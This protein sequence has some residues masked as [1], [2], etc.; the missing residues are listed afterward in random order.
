MNKKSGRNILPSAIS[1]VLLIVVAIAAE[2]LYGATKYLPL[3]LFALTCLFPAVINLLVML[4]RLRLPEEK[5]EQAENVPVQT[6]SHELIEEQKESAENGEETRKGKKRK[7][8]R[9]NGKGSSKF[10]KAL[11]AVARFYNRNRIWTASIFVLAVT[12]FVQIRFYI[13]QSRLTSL[14]TMNYAVLVGMIFIFTV[15]IALDKWCLHAKTGDLFTDSLLKNLRSILAFLQ[16]ALVLMMIAAALKL[17]GVYDVQTWMRYILIVLFYYMSAF[18]LFSFVVSVI[19][20]SLLDSPVLIVPSPFAI[21]SSKELGLITYF[22]ENTGMTMRSLWS[23]RMIKKLIPYTVVLAALLFWF[24][25]GVVQV[26]ANQTAVV[27]R[28]GQMIDEPL[29][30]GIHLCLPQPFDK[31]EIYNTEDVQRITVGYVSDEDQ[32]NTWTDKHG[33]EEYQLLLGSADEL[34]SINLRIEYKIG[35]ICKYLSNNTAP[36]SIVEALAYELIIDHTINNDLETLLS[37]DRE[38][39]AEHFMLDLID[40]ISHYN[41]GIDIVSVVLESIHPPIDIASIYQEVISAEIEAQKKIIEATG[42]AE[43]VIAYA[44]K[45]RDTEVYTATINQLSAV[46][47]ATA[48]VS[49]FMASV[50]A[51]QNYPETYRYYKYLNAISQAYGSTRIVIV[52]DGVDSSNLYFG[53]LL[54]SGSGA[55]STPT[56]SE[57]VGE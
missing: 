23:M 49:E 24:A 21:G 37:I 54:I 8:K 18:V 20:K 2:I 42:Y 34:V 43:Q 13:V 46:A 5:P 55:S 17:F 27:Y 50:G 35:D 10:K 30:P 19:K 22:E 47:S 38:A 48:S 29:R 16:F 31:V 25:T 9:K 36:E 57:T 7:K 1:A 12:V 14:Y 41:M 26:E 45:Q 56:D 51:D 32:D 52:G 39:F 40:G 44:E 4:L 15:F 28:F 33:R 11:C 3:C 6:E 53:S